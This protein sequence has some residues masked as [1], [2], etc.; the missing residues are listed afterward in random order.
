MLEVLK[1][2]F[3]HSQAQQSILFALLGQS[4]IS[5]CLSGVY[6]A[7]IRSCL[8]ISVLMRYCVSVNKWLAIGKQRRQLVQC[9]P[10]PLLGKQDYWR[11]STSRTLRQ[12]V[13]HI[14][15]AIIIEGALRLFQ[16]LRKSMSSMPSELLT[17]GRGV[18]E[19]RSTREVK[20]TVKIGIIVTFMKWYWLLIMVSL[21][22][23]PIINF[24]NV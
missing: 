16:R 21:P 10:S 24:L 12:R 18:L 8:C 14:T 2:M 9:I 23:F 19:L 15:N 6:Q 3:P 5:G 17:T 11:K 7:M 4:I 22:W 20:R 1:I 13:V